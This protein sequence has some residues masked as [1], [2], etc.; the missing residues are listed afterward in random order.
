MNDASTDEVLSYYA[1]GR[2]MAT[3]ATGLFVVAGLALAVFLGGATTRFLAGPR[4]SWALTGLVGAVGTVAIFA[5]VVGTEVAL[6][7]IA[8]GPDPSLAALEALWALHNGVFTVLYVMLGIALLGL[9]RAG[10]AAGL[11]PRVFEK[12][13][14]IG[15]AGLFISAAAGPF[16]A[17]GD[18]MALFGLGGL[19]FLVWLAFL[20]TTGRNLM[21]S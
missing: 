18:A 9:S 7:V 1:D 5:L 8:L 14:P 10:V 21:R 13:G 2:G 15:A 16:I 11:T 3:L 6:S 17:A 12:L 19:G 20:V 4:P